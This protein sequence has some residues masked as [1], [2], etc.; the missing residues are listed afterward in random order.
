[1]VYNITILYFH[2]LYFYVFLWIMMLCTH[3]IFTLIMYFY[4]LCSYV[5]LWFSRTFFSLFRDSNHGVLSRMC[6]LKYVNPKYIQSTIEQKGM[7][8]DHDFVNSFSIFSSLLKKR[9]KE[10]RIM[11]SK[12]R[13]QKACLSTRSQ[14]TIKVNYHN[15]WF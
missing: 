12:N 15:I 11:N 14:S 5:L 1:M 7:T 2:D 6:T 10:K 8:F 9:G 13:D 4:D 3:M